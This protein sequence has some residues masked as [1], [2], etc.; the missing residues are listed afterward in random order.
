MQAFHVHR[1]FQIVFPADMKTP[2][3]IYF[4]D[5]DLEKVPASF[6]STTYSFFSRYRIKTAAYNILASR[7]EHIVVKTTN[8]LSYLRKR[9]LEIFLLKRNDIIK[10]KNK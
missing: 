7:S 2:S 6:L 5:Q 1:N 8:A 9:K 4:K 3:I 10:V